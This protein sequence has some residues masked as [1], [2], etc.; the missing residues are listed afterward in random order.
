MRLLNDFFKVLDTSPTA[1]GF[2]ATI[3]LNPGHIVYTG[4]F[5]GFPV[6]PGVIQIQIVQELLEQHLGRKLRLSTMPQCKFLKI[7][8]PNETQ[9][10]VVHI[11]CREEGE[12]VHVKARAEHERDVFFRI[13]A[14]HT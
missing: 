2:V 11:E 9:R 6:T 14:T 8:N 10:L 3:Q 5:P 4:H 12:V 1:A 7:L 13:W